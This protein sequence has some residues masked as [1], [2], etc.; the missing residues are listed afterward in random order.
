MLCYFIGIFHPDIRQISM[1]F[2]DNKDSVFCTMGRP[3]SSGK[4]EEEKQ[5]Q[6]TKNEKTK[7][8]QKQEE[9]STNRSRT[10]VFV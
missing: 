5:N 1:L 9:K 7:T 3:C 4:T 6:K 2:K 8:K 10:K